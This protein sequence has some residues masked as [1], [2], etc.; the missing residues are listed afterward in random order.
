MNLWQTNPGLLALFAT[1]LTIGAYL[2]G[3]WLRER[4]QSPFANP[5]LI[6]I[7]LIGVT[8][9]LAH[10]SYAEY[11][12][13]AQFI[14][15]LLGPA[16][17]ALAIPLVNSLSHIRRTLWPMLAA[18]TCGSLV[19][20]VAGY[21]LVRLFGGS[22]ALALS[23]MPKSATTPI[24]I[25]V[26]QTINGI[27]SLTAVFAIAGGIL[28]AVGINPLLNKLGWDEPAALGLAAGTAGSGIGAS[29]VI[30][31]HSVAAAFAGIAIGINGAITAI[32]APLLVSI[33]MHWFKN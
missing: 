14:H 9:R 24:A 33:I 1:L 15:F 18:L 6:A 2:A 3:L 17:V 29:Q 8:L 20:V 32:V 4:L 31:Q 16:T 19:G 12:S 21:G 7:V 30:P 22:Q 28:V 26:S 13:G 23:M 10:L 5:V 25:S 11:F 27:P